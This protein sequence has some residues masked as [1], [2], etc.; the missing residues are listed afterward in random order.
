[1]AAKDEKRKKRP[2]PP[3]SPKIPA[4]KRIPGGRPVQ[5]K[6]EK[7]KQP[8]TT[9]GPAPSEI[10]PPKAKPGKGP[11][12]S[13]SGHW[14][15]LGEKTEK[16]EEEK[17]APAPARKFS[18]KQIAAILA[19]FMAIGFGAAALQ[20]AGV[21]GGGGGGAQTWTITTNSGHTATL[22]VDSSG[23]F[24]GTGWTGVSPYSGSYS[25]PITDGS[26][27]GTTMTFTASA[28]YDSGQGTIYET[29]YGTMNAAFPDAT[30]ATGTCSYTISDPLGTNSGSLS[31]TATRIS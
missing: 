22:T 8:E 18:P 14:V 7:P 30:S 6:Y 17:K 3:R 26:M 2:V 4:P 12:R 21:F 31:W 15:E 11:D 10:E 25:I 13:L 5:P 9:T 16:K 1:M 23:S 27:Y 20:R 24:T 28:T 19:A 29:G